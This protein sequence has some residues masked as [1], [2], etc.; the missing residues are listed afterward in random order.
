[1]IEQREREGQ[2]AVNRLGRWRITVNDCYNYNINVWQRWD[3]EKSNQNM[4]P[5]L[6]NPLFRSYET[7]ARHIFR[8]RRHFKYTERFVRNFLIQAWM[9]ITLLKAFLSSYLS[10]EKMY[11]WKLILNNDYKLSKSVFNRIFQ[12]YLT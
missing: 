11:A 12:F 1:M 3:F 10:S 2:P 7:E 6:L 8:V 4:T 5:K 9:F